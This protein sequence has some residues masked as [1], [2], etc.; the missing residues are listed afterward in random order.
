MTPAQRTHLQ[1]A[2]IALAAVL[3]LVVGFSAGRFSA[4]LQ[5][6]TREVERVVFKDLLVEDITKGFTFAR[7]IEKTV[8]RNVETRPDGTTVDRSIERHGGTTAA[9]VTETTKRTEE[10]AGQ[11]EVEKVTIT[12]LRPSWSIGLLVGATWKE[13]ALP[14]AGPLV[15]GATVDLRLGQTP[16]SVGAWG[17]TQGAFGA[18]GRAEF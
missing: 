16:F 1:R 11:R 5:V 12:T 15:L 2:G 17:T 8:W 7:T 10:H 13:P 6:E 14:I 9:T 18:I 4:P 3:L